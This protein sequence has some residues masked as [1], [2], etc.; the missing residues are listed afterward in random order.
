M[1]LLFKNIGLLVT[2]T[3]N[4]PRKGKEQGEIT[5]IENAVV[6]V[7]GGKIA[8]VGTYDSFCDLHDQSKLESFRDS[9]DQSKLELPATQIFDCDGKLVTPGLVDAHTHLVFGGWREKELG[10]KLAGV[11]YLDILKAGGGILNTVE[12]TRKATEAELT[13]KAM[14]LLTKMLYHGTTT[15]ECKSGYGLNLEDERKQLRVS[16]TLNKTHPADVVSTFLGAHA[17]PHE[18]REN[19]GEYIRLLCEEILPKIAS[20][21]I[22]RYCDIFCETAVFTPKESVKILTR[23]KELGFE[24]KIHADEIDPIG[25]AEI[26]ALL[27]SVSADHLIQASDKGISDMAK[28]GVIAVLLPATSFYL[29]KPFARARKMIDEGV[30]VAVATDFNPGSS[31]NFNLQLAMNLACLRYKLTPAEVIT[32]VTLNAAAAIG[33]AKEVGTL[34]V[35]KKA[36]IVIWDAPNLE[37]IFYRYGNN[38]VDTV[39]KNG[40]VFRVTRST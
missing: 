11:P 15:V 14:E 35:G 7:N 31:P 38:L 39:V 36:D 33:M 21:G 5:L 40:E 34:E 4:E 22:A 23:A 12:H 9:Q 18:Y 25:G 20:D 17:F 30:A 19:R 8:Y 27:G 32:A 29:E 26:S 37:Y 16:A 1:E 24:L 6:G 10:L 28:K 13:E 3:G 2:P